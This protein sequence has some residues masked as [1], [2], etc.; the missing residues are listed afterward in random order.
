MKGTAIITG[1]AKRLGRDIALDL[2]RLGWDIALHYNQS[3]HEARDLRQEIIAAGR[4]CTIY[5][6]DLS[7]M[8]GVK[9]L[10][11]SVFAASPDCRVLVN[12]AAV[13]ERADLAGTT[14]ELFDLHMSVNLKAP[15]FLA[16]MFAARAGKGCVVNMLDSR[17]A[18]N[19]GAYFAYTLSKKALADFTLMA[20]SQLA[21]DIRVNGVCP[22]PILP[23]A[24]Q[25]DETFDAIIPKIP[26]RRKGEADEVVSAVRFLVENDYVTGQFLFVDGGDHLRE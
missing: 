14:E 17:V 10:I 21:P 20:A 26:M 6:A 5:K 13:F 2:A 15:I 3:D 25:A 11:S 23:P 8:A 4:H 12:N 19:V 18:R 1:G 7:R 9:K 24:D 16:Q 22:G